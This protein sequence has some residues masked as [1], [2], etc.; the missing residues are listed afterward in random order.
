MD[1]K[2]IKSRCNQPVTKVFFNNHSAIIL[3]PKHNEALRECLK[4][5]LSDRF[6][7]DDLVICSNASRLCG[8]LIPSEFRHG[9]QYSFILWSK[10]IDYVNS[11][12]LIRFQGLNINSK[13]L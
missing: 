10:S 2:S 9:H 8:F 3:N 1:L 11:I 6:T 12:Y 13:V 7:E 5:S 4:K